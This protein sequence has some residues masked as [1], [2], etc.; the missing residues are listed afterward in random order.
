MKIEAGYK[1]TEKD[2]WVKVEGNIA[3]DRDQRPRPGPVL[4]YRIP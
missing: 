4:R 3:D 1:Y 2:E